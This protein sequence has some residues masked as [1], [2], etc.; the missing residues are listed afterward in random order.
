MPDRNVLGAGLGRPRACGRSYMAKHTHCFRF[1]LSLGITC[2]SLLAQTTPPT[3]SFT[4]PAGMQRGTSGIFL[5][6]GTGLA[7]AS[8]IVFS[9]PGLVG[10]I[11]EV[12]KVPESRLALETKVT[13]VAKPY[14]EDPVKMQAKVEIR[15]EDWMATGT[16]LFRII[17][18]RGSSTPGRLVVSTFPERDEQDPNDSLSGCADCDLTSHGQWSGAGGRRRRLLPLSGGGRTGSGAFKST[19]RVPLWILWLTSSTATERS[20]QAIVTSRTDR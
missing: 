6:E 7:G 16:H 14:F 3:V 9:E 1:L 17:T 5:I 13:V 8:E 10:K 18:P 15:A 20:W 2:G 12:G 19:R 11:L 4:S